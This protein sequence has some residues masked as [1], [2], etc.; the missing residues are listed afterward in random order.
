MTKEQE[1]F[2]ERI[3][4]KLE[5]I[6]PSFQYIVNPKYNIILNALDMYE[7]HIDKIIKENKTQ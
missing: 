6:D 7:N 1:M 4:E 5:K 2:I 3:K